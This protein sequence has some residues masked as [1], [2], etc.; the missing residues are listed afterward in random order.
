MELAVEYNESSV[1]DELVVIPSHPEGSFLVSDVLKR[2]RLVRYIRIRRVSEE[3]LKI[4]E[5]GDRDV[6]DLGILYP[7]AHDTSSY[8]IKAPYFGVSEPGT[9]SSTIR[10]DVFQE[11]EPHQE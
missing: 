4:I 11:L 3:L 7:I 8:A 10:I 6:I 2:S 1:G 5:N 9:H